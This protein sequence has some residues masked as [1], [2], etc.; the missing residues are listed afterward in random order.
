[1]V[2]R[3]TA[4]PLCFALLITIGFGSF[5]SAQE[6]EA[7]EMV[8]RFIPPKGFYSEAHRFIMFSVIEGC[9]NDGV[10]DADIDAILPLDDKGH[11]DQSKHFVYACPA[12]SPALDG[13]A[14]Y[15]KRPALS[16]QKM[17]SS[18]KA[19]NTFGQGLDPET[20]IELEKGGQAGR[21]AV[22][23][24][25]KKWVDERILRHR[26][27]AEE[28]KALRLE[29]AKMRKEGEKLLKG[30]RAGGNGDRLQE[31]YSDWEQ[32]CPICSGASPTMMGLE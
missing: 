28:E 16:F 7:K 4:Q 30:F 12:C 2:S 25:T 26:F 11:R 9:Y 5:V 13:F 23:K 22:Q 17:K 14:L 32:G 10:S 24:L 27:T 29:F 3:M 6:D 21:D 1:M 8:V 19:F 31:V 20:R 18:G 15:A